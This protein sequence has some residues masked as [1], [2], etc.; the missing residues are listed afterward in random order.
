[1]ILSRTVAALCKRHAQTPQSKESEAPS[2]WR[3]RLAR[4][5][6]LA[7]ALTDPAQA[8][9]D[10]SGSG[11][12]DIWERHFNNG[13]LFD[14]ENPDHH[15]DADPDG[16]GWTNYQESIAGT[17]PF[18]ANPPDGMVAVL[19]AYI[20]GSND[21]QTYD[22][23][24]V[25]WDTLPGK[26]YTIKVSPDLTATSWT[27]VGPPILGSG[28]PEGELITLND[29]V[30][31]DRLFWRV[32]VDDPHID[33]DGDGLTDYE[34]FLLGSNPL[35]A[36]TS[37]D[38][39]PDR[40]L[41]VHGFNPT[42]NH[43][44]VFFQDS[45]FT[46]PEAYHMGVQAHPDA[47]LDD[48]D[49]DGV[50]NSLDAVPWEPHASWQKSPESGYLVIPLG[51]PSGAD[52]V[53]YPWEQEDLPENLWWLPQGPAGIVSLS[54]DGGV[55]LM[56]DRGA[57][58]SSKAEA[59]ESTRMWR[60][61]PGGAWEAV[62][63]PSNA[64][65]QNGS[66]SEQGVI[67]GRGLVPLFS[68]GN[69]PADGP[70]VAARVW[71]KDGNQTNLIHDSVALM[72]G[73]SAGPP[74][75]VATSFTSFPTLGR[76]AMSDT[77]EV[78]L[79]E[80][81]D[82]GIETPYRLKRGAVELHQWDDAENWGFFAQP[83]FVF[84]RDGDV[85]YHNGVGLWL[86]PSDPVAGSSRPGPNIASGPAWITGSLARLSVP[87]E[88]GVETRMA[89]LQGNQLWIEQANGDWKRIR[90]TP[91]DVVANADGI[92][93][94]G[95]VGITINHRGEIL[96]NN[97]TLWRNGAYHTIDS[98]VHDDAWVDFS[99]SH[100]NN[101]GVMVG[102]SRKNNDS[103]QVIMLVPMEA[104][105]EVLAVNSNFDEGR[106]DPDTGYAIPDCDDMPGVCP[107][108]GAG[109][110]KMALEAVRDHLDGD[111]TQ[112]E[113]ITN[114]L[115][116]GWFGVHPETFGDEFWQDATVTIRKIDRI[117]DDTGH[118]ESGQVRFYA[119]WGDGPSQYRG[120]PTYDPGTLEAANLVTGGINKAPEE[121]VYG[122]NSIIPENAVFYMEGIRAG[123]ITLEWRYE[124]GDV[125]LSYE[126]T[127]LVAT[128][129]SREE[130]IEQ[131][132]YQVKLQSAE[133]QA[134]LSDP[135]YGTLFGH[136]LSAFPIDMTLYEPYAG[137]FSYQSKNYV[138]I[139]TI[140]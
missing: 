43:E 33:S 106:I 23:V 137:L 60:A 19:V 18:S 84:S 54:A 63:W 57:L 139:Q 22:Q 26:Q 89:W 122:A 8:Q 78:C 97:D 133:L 13:E 3:G 108:T 82:L 1:M 29:A 109:N 38:G 134:V 27:A 123:K 58:I 34:E 55:L 119:K 28:Q 131:L 79:V 56:E 67:M 102:F 99:I 4:R 10:T 12:S 37:G 125:E 17:D 113:R 77:G 86:E 32:H 138:Y 120:I 126:Q 68:A 118:P 72:S 73:I 69:Q 81:T 112:Y 127:F 103:S 75:N 101:T 124:K 42:D 76:V 107:V 129:Q 45:E 44:L 114:N 136:A 52:G 35:A 20:H 140:Y 48:F 40:W 135:Q 31:P 90:R 15:P 98:L 36:D 11:M 49:G 61:Y 115:H 24:I 132:N 46:V 92:G 5:L 121:S 47:T 30:V 80:A 16:D 53:I 95:V 62:T 51:V 70:G 64:L 88:N 7:A 111:Y 2:T 116:E 93:E 39:I 6:L 74:F 110:T 83:E 9:L 59:A 100:L 104:V 21:P 128:E 91:E 50:P 25:T 94:S 130:W 66:L 85:M 71:L 87:V 65:V 96:V 41:V 14:P 105:P 117:D